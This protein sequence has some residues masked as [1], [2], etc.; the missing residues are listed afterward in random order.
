MNKNKFDAAQ[1]LLHKIDACDLLLLIPNQNSIYAELNS[2]YRTCVVI[3]TDLWC[4]ITE[5]VKQAKQQYE[6]EFNAL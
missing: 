3:P 4:K 5:V 1:E 2:T 6:E